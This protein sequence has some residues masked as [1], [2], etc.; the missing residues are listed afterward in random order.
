[1][2][3]DNPPQELALALR[4][5]RSEQGLTQ[6]QVGD[7]LGVDQSTYARYEAGTFEPDRTRELWDRLQAFLNMETSEFH[8]LMIETSFRIRERRAL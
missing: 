6:K 8:G 7:L 3:N 5:R 1:M 2:H 4:A